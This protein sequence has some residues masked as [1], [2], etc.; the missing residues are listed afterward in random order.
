MSRVVALGMRF[1]AD[2]SSAQ[3]AYERFVKEVQGKPITVPITSAASAAIASTPTTTLGGLA[4]PGSVSIG[5]GG[6]NVTARVPSFDA[7]AAQVKGGMTTLAKALYAQAY[8]LREQTNVLRGQSGGSSQAVEAG[9]GNASGIAT[10]VSSRN[11][12]LLSRQNLFGAFI[13]IHGVQ[14]VARE[15]ARERDLNETLQYDGPDAAARLAAQ[16]TREDRGNLLGSAIRS[17]AVLGTRGYLS[18]L[19]SFG[20]Y[21]KTASIIGGSI[22]KDVKTDDERRALDLENA[23]ILEAKDKA[24]ALR[25][26]T[27]RLRRDVQTVDLDPFTKQSV[28]SKSRLDEV[29]DRAAEFK[30]RAN[31]LD[32]IKPGAGKELRDA[33]KDNENAASKI[34][35]AMQKATG[36]AR[37]SAL[38]VLRSDTQAAIARG[39][40]DPIAASR[41][42]LDT[43]LDERVR[44]A[45]RRG[46]PELPEIIANAKARRDEFDAT[47][48]REIELETLSRTNAAGVAGLLT[49]NRPLDA[50]IQAIRNRQEEQQRAL[51]KGFL[52]DALGGKGLRDSIDEEADAQ[53]RLEE[54]QHRRIGGDVGRSQATRLEEIARLRERD[55][56]GAQAAGTV[57]DT[58]AQARKLYQNQLPAE[59]A[60]Q[61]EVGTAELELQ[62]FN[63]R[64]AFRGEAVDLRAFDNNNARDTEDP[65]KILGEINKGIQ[66]LA[67]AVA[68]LGSD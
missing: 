19:G 57:G 4:V 46:V 25:D 3:S 40:N 43:E 21:G 45:T 62:K 35:D 44:D 15:Y 31:A 30:N 23:S 1:D 33:A 2:L 17:T 36:V 7:E 27:R 67:K 39:R 47:N 11:S 68:D 6:P 29:A 53:I 41:F 22:I 14:A 59:A 64:E 38:L 24:G 5:P 18:L 10:G 66:D 52:F 13:A 55:P 61:L 48:R 49:N 34:N 26:S 63:Y 9:D 20:I 28:E 58:I 50:R 37:D 65:A 16:Q 51:P 54:K 12:Q 42:K 56:V 32:A 60:K 8:V